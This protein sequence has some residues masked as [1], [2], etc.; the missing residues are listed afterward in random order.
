MNRVAFL[1]DG[2]NLYHSARQASREL[3]GASTKWLDIRSLCVEKLSVI[4]RD[5]ALDSI[6]YFS[7]LALH[8]NPTNP[9]VTIRHETYLECL[10]DSGVEVALARF[11]PKTV[12]CPNCGTRITR[13]EEKET[14]VAIAVKLM[15]LFY[16][17][18]C[19]TAVILTGDTDIAPAV[20]TIQRV[21][22]Q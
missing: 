14:D 12:V 10:R 1:V 2:F 7:A 22:P 19:D 8:L 21:F 5:A 6:H 15:E 4:G 13:H 16:A 17:D 18:S 11:K 3:G 9:G 20:R